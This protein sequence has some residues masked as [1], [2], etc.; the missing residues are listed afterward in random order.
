[1]VGENVQIYGVQIPENALASQKIESGHF[2]SC[3]Q[4]KTLEQVL[5]ITPPGREKLLILPRQVFKASPP[6]ST[7][8]GE[9]L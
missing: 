8:R 4:G 9:G 5:I 2:Y 7:G 3:P 1:M 6:P